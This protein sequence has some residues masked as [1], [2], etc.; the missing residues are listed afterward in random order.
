MIL[1]LFGLLIVAAVAQLLISSGHRG[2]FQGPTSPGQ[3]P[4]LSRA[5]TP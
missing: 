3:L 4:S 1:V 5:P 2:P